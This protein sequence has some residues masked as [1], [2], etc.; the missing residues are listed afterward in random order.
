MNTIKNYLQKR[1]S[2]L[3]V[4]MHVQ[5]LFVGLLCTL[6]YSFIVELLLSFTLQITIL[7]NIFTALSLL[8]FF[9]FKREYKYTFIFISVIYIFS[10]FFFQTRSDI[11]S[12]DITQVSNALP[13]ENTT[14]PLTLMAANILYSN[15]SYNA[16]AE[17]FETT[18]SDVL[19]IIEYTSK[20]YDRLHPTLEKI[21]PYSSLEGMY[22]QTLRAH[23][24]ISVLYSKYEIKSFEEILDNTNHYSGFIRA[25]I[26]EQDT[27]FRIYGIHTIAPITKEYLTRRNSQVNHLEQLLLEDTSENIIAAGDFNLSPWSPIFESFYKNTQFKNPTLKNGFVTTWNLMNIPFVSSH[28]DHV[29]VNSKPRVEKTQVL[30]IPG[31]DHKATYTTLFLDP[32]IQEIKSEHK[33]RS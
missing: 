2:G 29:F 30:N 15:D 5:F 16:L 8:Y 18:N 14:T 10:I 19:V 24:G 21:Y 31:S 13:A 22:E 17:F 33:E 9:K 27:P 32:E 25:D 28:I 20:H 4:L 26:I 12:R 11:Y 6:T 3:F 7:Y 23:K 1:L